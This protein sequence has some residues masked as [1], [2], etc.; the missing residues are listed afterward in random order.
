MVPK[1]F[2]KYHGSSRLGRDFNYV[3]KRKYSSLSELKEDLALLDK[4]RVR[5]EYV[6]EFKPQKGTL[7]QEGTAARL[8]SLDGKQ[9]LNGGGY[10]GNINVKDLPKRT[11]I[12]TDRVEF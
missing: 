12:W 1:A 7:I 8:I 10:Q 4:W 6:S 3:T 9:V 11:I 2:Y 5:F